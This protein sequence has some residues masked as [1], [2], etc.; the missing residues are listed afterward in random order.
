MRQG[1]RDDIPNDHGRVHDAI[2]RARPGRAGH[3]R[4]AAR[5]G[6]GAA[7]GDGAALPGRGCV[8]QRLP[9]GERTEGAVAYSPGVSD[10][11]A[12]EPAATE[13]PVAAYRLYDRAGQLL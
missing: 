6:L 4:P 3:D 5:E 10:R 11:V 13:L 9:D 1:G 7:A 8:P 12:A 2:R